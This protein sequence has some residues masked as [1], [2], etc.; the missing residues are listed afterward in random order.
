MSKYYF[1][2]LYEDVIVKQIFYSK[3]AAGLDLLD[4][5][6]IDGIVRTIDRFGRNIGRLIAQLQTG[7]LQSYGVVTSFGVLLMFGI[8]LIFR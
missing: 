5:S 1:D 6:F 4:K 3:L 8:Y 2:E 7:Q